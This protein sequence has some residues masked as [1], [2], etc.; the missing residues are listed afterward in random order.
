VQD[1][2]YI[3]GTRDYQN[4]Q[5]SKYIHWKASARQHR[6]Q[7]KV[8]ESTQQ[9]K[10]LLVVNV[11]PF[12]RREAEED[13]EHA[14]EVVASLAVLL[15]QQGH[16]VGLVAN[17][18]VKGGGPAIVPV[19]RNDQQ[20]PAILELLARLQMKPDRDLKELL[21]HKLTLTWGIS[22]IYFSHEEDQTV[23]SAEEYFTQRRT[24]VVF[25]VCR[26]PLPAG[27]ERLGA[28]RKVYRLDD[29]CSET[30]FRS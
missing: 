1:P 25:F 28:Q 19:A 26:P 22:C 21:R 16:S 30:P 5:P 18:K 14:L 4:G 10:V 27:R 29:I 9:E 12:A 11:D 7:E 8:F 3:L 24:P 20:L 6:L 13:F 23:F 17:G 2:V 15:S